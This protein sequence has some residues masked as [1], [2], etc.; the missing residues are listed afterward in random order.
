MSTPIN[1]QIRKEPQTAPLY[2]IQIS[3]STPGGRTML[4]LQTNQHSVYSLSYH[5]ILVTKYRHPCMTQEIQT[6]IQE[7]VESLFEKWGCTLIELNGEIDHIHILFEA[8]PQIRLASTINSLKSVTSRYIRKEF[9]EEL[10]PF[11]WKPYFWSNS[12]FLI[13]TGGAPIEIIRQY[14][15]DQGK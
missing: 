9:P 14:I 1:M 7:V 3:Y 15:E 11:Y 13:S 10:E 2:H 6:R 12:Y 5:L 8:P 4:N